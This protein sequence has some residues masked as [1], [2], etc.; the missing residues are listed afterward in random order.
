MK[1]LIVLIV[2]VFSTSTVYSSPPSKDE[3]KDMGLS[4]YESD[5]CLGA[6]KYLFAYLIVDDQL[7][8]KRKKSIKAAIT[9]CES[10]LAP[11]KTVAGWT[12]GTMGVLSSGGTLKPLQFGSGGVL[13]TS[14]GTLSTVDT[15]TGGVLITAG[16]VLNTID[17]STG[18]VLITAGGV[19]NTIDTSKGGILMT[20]GGTLMPIEIGT[21]E[22]LITTEDELNRGIG[23][24][25]RLLEGKEKI[26]PSYFGYLNNANMYKLD[27]DKL[28]E[29]AFDLTKVPGRLGK[30]DLI[31]P[32][33]PSVQKE[34]ERRAFERELRSVFSGEKVE[35]DGYGDLES[36][37]NP[38]LGTESLM[39]MRPYQ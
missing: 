35:L 1:Y 30:F 37:K 24:A 25:V 5:D 21:G 2:L 14:G 11:V 19:L 18:G 13:V 26:E 32:Y 29:P 16:G 20:A 10:V 12:P 7:D 23:K 9:H 4:A 31:K 39:P 34:L 8:Q 17:T 33:S 6:V 36:M 27:T 15:S 28:V 22:L 38:N 3:L